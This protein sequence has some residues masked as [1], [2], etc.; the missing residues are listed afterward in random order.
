M[1]YRLLLTLLLLLHLTAAAIAADADLRTETMDMLVHLRQDGAHKRFPDE[2]RSLDETMA[3]ADLYHRTG[4]T[5]NAERHYRLAAQKGLLIRQHLTAA[6]PQPLVQQPASSAISNQPSEELQPPPPEEPVTSNRLVGTIGEYRVVKG[7]TLRIVA[8]KLGVSR[9]QLATMN[10]LS[11]TAKLAIGQ[12]LRYNNRRIVPE[13]RLKDGII[14]NIPDRMLYL[15]QK[16]KLAFSTPVALGTPTKTEQFV[17]QTPTGRFKILAKDKDPTWTV[18]PS[19]QEEMRLEGKEVITSVPPGPE[20][21]LGKYA[22]KTSLPG[23]L[24]HSTTKPWSIYTFA[25]HGCIRVYPER[26]EELFKLVR[27]NTTGEIIYRPVKLVTT[28]GGRVFLEVHG[29]IYEKT[30]GIER[31]AHSLIRSRGLADRVDWK[32]IKRV[33]SRKSGIAEEITRDTVESAQTEVPDH[34]PS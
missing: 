2:M 10:D 5:E 1:N 25:S 30:K 26:M 21:P 15:F 16:G 17:W 18:P 14:I 11:S 28:E 34:S 33:I 31:E 6:L 20:N 4:D 23:I 32:K 3:T 13:H 7:D 8:A 22:I 24:I 9:A 29:D 19:I 12:V 27:V